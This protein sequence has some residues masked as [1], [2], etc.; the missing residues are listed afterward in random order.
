[1]LSSRHG[2]QFLHPGRGTQ[3]VRERSAKPL[4]VGSIPTRASTFLWTWIVSLA[5]WRGC[6]LS[7]LSQLKPWPPSRLALGFL[8]RPSSID[9]CYPYSY[10]PASAGCARFLRSRWTNGQRCGEGC[11]HGR[12]PLRCQPRNSSTSS[13]DRLAAGKHG[14][15]GRRVPCVRQIQSRRSSRRVTALGARSTCAAR[16]EKRRDAEPSSSRR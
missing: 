15:R 11:E 6:L 16:G 4:C 5:G 9:R 8:Q 12:V 1:M 7:L 10:G 14:K 3:V 13:T 2:R